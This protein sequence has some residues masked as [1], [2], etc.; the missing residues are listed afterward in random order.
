MARRSNYRMTPARRAALRKAQLASARKR[1]RGASF[2]SSARATGRHINR[3]RGKYIAAVAV[4]GAVAGHKLSGSELSIGV[5]RDPRDS[6]KRLAAPG[7]F[8]SPRQIGV[9]RSGNTISAMIKPVAGQAGL[10]VSYRIGRGAAS[11]PGPSKSSS[12]RRRVSLSELPVAGGIK[13][14]G[15]KVVDDALTYNP[16]SAAS[17]GAAKSRQVGWGTYERGKVPTRPAGNIDAFIR[18]LNNK[19]RIPNG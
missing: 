14:R 10:G 12:P 11:S 5:K 4:V 3:N 15:G 8:V 6:Q 19:Y 13:S 7:R 17:G 9:S 2:K 16:F 1:S 18:R